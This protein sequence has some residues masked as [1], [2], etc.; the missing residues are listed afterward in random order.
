MAENLNE[1][2]V[3]TTATCD[4]SH[5]TLMSGNGKFFLF[6]MAI[7]TQ[8]NTEQLVLFSANFST[9]AILWMIVSTAVGYMP[10]VTL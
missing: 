8:I 9:W 4:D 2:A 1:E 6:V 7:N 5:L 3:P 10:L